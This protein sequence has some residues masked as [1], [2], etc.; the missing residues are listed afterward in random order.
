MASDEH[1]R[2]TQQT[3]TALFLSAPVEQITGVWEFHRPSGHRSHS[4]SLPGH[5]L[6]LVT[7]GAYRLRSNGREYN[8]CTGDIIYYFETEEVHWLDCEGPVSFRSVGFTAPLLQPLPL[9]ERVF[10]STP[11]MRDAFQTLCAAALRV[12]P[13]ERSLACH[14]ALNRLLLEILQQRELS[15]FSSPDGELWWRVEQEVRR[16]RR[17]RPTLDELAE[18]FGCSRATL[19]RAS[20][21]AVGL[22]PGRRLRGIR[23][24]EAKGLLQMSSLTITQIA[25]YLGYP[26]LQEFSREFRAFYHCSPKVFRHSCPASG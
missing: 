19:C 11:T 16:R 9:A 3:L 13:L 8:V 1:R 25:E 23:M 18:R 7:E 20:Q 21:A 4:R 14:S 10:P 5:L 15:A 17:F 6:H 24:A 12:N 2:I 26:R 22:S